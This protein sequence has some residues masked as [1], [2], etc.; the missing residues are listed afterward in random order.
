MCDIVVFAL[1][2]A[3][4]WLF[5]LAGFEELRNACG[6]VDV[7]IQYASQDHTSQKSTKALQEHCQ[8]SNQTLRL[9]RNRSGF[10]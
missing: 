10:F 8:G 7:Y 9:L 2:F 4:F 3:Y 5:E 6:Q 1:V